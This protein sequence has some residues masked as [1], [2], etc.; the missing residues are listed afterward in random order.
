[1]RRELPTDVLERAQTEGRQVETV[2]EAV[3]CLGRH[4]T[5]ADWAR[6]DLVK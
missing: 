6:G 3:D 4:G 5:G 2:R 1:M